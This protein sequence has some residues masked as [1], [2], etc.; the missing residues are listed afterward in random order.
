MLKKVFEPITINGLTLKNRMVVPA[1][2]T[3]YCTID[4]FATEQYISYHEAKAKGGWG[5]IIAEDYRIAPNTGAS[6]ILPGLFT[7]EHIQSHHELTKRVHAAGGKIFAQIYHAGLQANRELYGIQPV[8]VSPVKNAL[9][10]ELPHVLTVAEIKEIE[11]QFADCAVN[12]KKA[13]FDGIEIHGAHGYL[14]NQFLS[15]VTNKRNEAYGGSLYNRCRMAIETVQVVREAVGEKFPISFRLTTKEYFEGGLKLEETKVFAKLLENAG[16]NILNCSQHGVPYIIPPSAVPQAFAVNNAAEIKKVVTIPVIGVGRINDPLLAESVLESGSMDMVAMGRASLADPEMPNKALKGEQDDIVHCIACTQ[17]CIG[18]KARGSVLCCLVNPRLGHESESEYT[19]Q[20]AQ[21]KKKVFVLGGG[22]SGCET[23]IVAAQKGHNVTIFEKTGALGGLWNA[24]AIP[25]AKTE[26]ATLVA[27]QQYQIKKFGIHVNYNQVLT[28]ELLEK[29][30]PDT[31]VVATGGN[32]FIPPIKGLDNY[33][34][35]SD[36]LLGKSDVG[37][38]VLIVGGGLVGAETAEYLGY[39][40]V[41]VTL[42]EMLDKIAKDGEV[43]PNSFMLQ[44]LD[45]FGV[46]IYTSTSV[47]EIAEDIVKLKTPNG[48]VVLNNIDSII[49]AAGFQP[50]HEADLLLSQY[51][52]TIITVGDAKKVKNGLHNLRE[53]YEAGLSI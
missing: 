9:L 2:V 15:P 48:E 1:M 39:H 30:N 44:N 36:I 6:A 38:N 17:G 35:A 42:V 21:K 27:R 5:L 25:L 28:K 13:G 34:T 50:N 33:V 32:P 41:K 43:A 18:E 45:K 31:I 7:E 12:A 16:V 24:A 19:I 47:D 52:G 14:I 49:I 4:G 3:K 20:S 29:E 53:A 46:N 11:Q 23:A 22:I 26:F 51:T 40:G 8:A 37:A 10:K